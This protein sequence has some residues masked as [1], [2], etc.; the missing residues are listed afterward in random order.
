MIKCKGADGGSW[1][2]TKRKLVRKRFHQV[3]P[4]RKTFKWRQAQKSV[5]LSEL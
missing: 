5:R 4:E 1:K 3:S 2:G